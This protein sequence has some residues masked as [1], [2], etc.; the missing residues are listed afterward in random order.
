MRKVSIMITAFQKVKVN[1]E[2]EW[3]E[4]NDLEIKDKIEKVLLKNRVSYCI[5]WSKPRLFSSEKN[6][7]CIFCVNSLQKENAEEAIESLPDDVKA[8]ITY[9]NK[10]VEKVYY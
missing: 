8:K 9:L 3:C 6:S 4:V 2:I 7:K 1:N 5:N 10:K